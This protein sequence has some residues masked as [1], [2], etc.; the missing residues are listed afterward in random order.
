MDSYSMTWKSANIKFSLILREIF[1]F[2]PASQFAKHG[3]IILVNSVS[4]QLSDS[5]AVCISSLGKNHIW[6]IIV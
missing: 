5:S 6:N 1:K 4:D 3:R 2:K